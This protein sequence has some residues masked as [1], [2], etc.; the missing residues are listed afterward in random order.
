MYDH[1]SKEDAIQLLE[2]SHKTI[3]FDQNTQEIDVLEHLLSL[4]ELFHFEKIGCSYSHIDNFL[5]DMV[6]TNYPDNYMDAYQSN[7]YYLIDPVVTEYLSSPDLLNWKDVGKKYLKD[8]NDAIDLTDQ[9]GLYDGYIYGT[10][11][12]NNPMKTVVMWG[13]SRVEKCKRTEAIV[14]YVTPFISEL[15]KKA[16]P[17]KQHQKF[18]LTKKEIEVL[19]WIKEGKTSWEIGMILGISE[20]TINFHINNIK[21]KL[22]CNNRCQA[23]AV[24]LNSKLISF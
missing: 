8:K 20:R 6:I 3:K 17:E 9:I 7:A 23:V 13:G 11:N 22:S 24:A 1:L 19:N 16:Y 4:Q 15:L 12:D 14:E 5:Q 18:N 10:V 2:F 21:N